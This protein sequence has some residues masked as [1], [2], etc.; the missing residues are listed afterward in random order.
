MG[1]LR[2]WD[3]GIAALL[4]PLLS[5]CAYRVASP[6]NLP[7]TFGRP[8]T[9]NRG[10]T[11]VAVEGAEIGDILGFEVGSLSARAR[12]S[13][14]PH[15][16][17]SVAPYVAYLYTYSDSTASRRLWGER[18]GLK[19]NGLS[20][21]FALLGGVGAGTHAAGEY[22]AFDAGAVVGYENPYFVP[23][24]SLRFHFSQPFG[25]RWVDLGTQD[26][27][28][29]YDKPN[30]TIGLSYDFGFCVPLGEWPGHRW[31]TPISILA[32]MEVA[33]LW[34]GSSRTDPSAD[35]M[36]L[37]GFVLTAE[38]TFPGTGKGP[39]NPLRHTH[40]AW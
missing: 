26:G 5:G 8:A 21:H 12:V 10:E 7:G 4:L 15:L 25:A 39:D 33:D 40:E 16:D 35:H 9:L 22:V 3:A 11:A 13:V 38:V 14:A 27:A 28:P 6:V 2:K 19:W 29:V 1:Q 30:T 31:P 20:K 23:L 36:G 32:G 24:A 37:V 17:L 18:I 34:R